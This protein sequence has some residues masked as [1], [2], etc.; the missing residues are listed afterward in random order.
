[1]N[2]YTWMMKNNINTM[3]PVGDLARDMEDDNEFPRDGKKAQVRGYLNRCGACSGCMEA[4][5]EAW[6]EYERETAGT[7]AGSGC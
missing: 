6:S 4:F 7:E 5:E 1:M 2:F 3:A